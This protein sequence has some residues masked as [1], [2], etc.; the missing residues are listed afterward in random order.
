MSSDDDGQFSIFESSG[1]RSAS[2]ALV[3]AAEAD[4]ARER[5]SRG[6]TANAFDESDVFIATDLETGHMIMSVGSDGRWARVYSDANLIPG[7]KEGEISH[8]WRKGA[9]LLDEL[10]FDVGVVLDAGKP[11]QRVI[12]FPRA[13]PKVPEQ[14]PGETE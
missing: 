11:H 2:S 1:R 12:R 13:T 9:R 6:A 4:T 7:F 10:P 5:A 3:R 8:T 14:A